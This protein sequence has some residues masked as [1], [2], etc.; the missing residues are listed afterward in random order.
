MKRQEHDPLLNEILAGEE[1]SDFR[2]TSLAQAQAAVRSR[3]CRRRAMKTGALVIVPVLA[4]IVFALRQ[5]PRSEV[6]ISEPAHV[7]TQAAAQPGSVRVISD[8]ELFAL[9]PNQEMALIGPPGHQK[10]VFLGQPDA[11][12]SGANGG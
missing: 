11:K 12:R 1:I 9:F 5:V 3:V 2:K 8:T 4:A 7:A 6:R 10:L